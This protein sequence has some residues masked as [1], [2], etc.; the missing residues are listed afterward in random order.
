LESGAARKVLNT[1]EQANE[2]FIR[3]VAGVS[4]SGESIY[5]SAEE[6]FKSREGVGDLFASLIE[7]KHPD[8]YLLEQFSQRAF[9]PVKFF[10]GFNDEIVQVQIQALLGNRRAEESPLFRQ[11]LVPSPDGFHWVEASTAQ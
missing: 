8:P 5:S 2:A 9:D 6:F 1:E 11:G 3:L 4:T 7:K 10:Q